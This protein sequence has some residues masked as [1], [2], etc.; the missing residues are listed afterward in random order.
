MKKLLLSLI[1]ILLLIPM[2][3]LAE[4]K[5]E[6]KSITFV[7]KSENTKINTEASTDGE[8]INLDLIFY[9]K[10][11]FATYKV[12]IYNPN[13]IDLFLN[14]I[15][16]NYDKEY[17]GYEFDSNTI[18]ANEEK[19][20]TLRVNYKKEVD[21]SLFRSGKYDASINE[22]L[23]FSSELLNI[24]NT[25]KN[26]GILRVVFITLI[27]ICVFFGF[28][29]IFKNDNK[30]VFNIILIGLLLIIIPKGASAIIKI[31]VPIDSKVIIKMV[32]DNPCVFEGNLTQGA[33]YINGQY[34]YRYMQHYSYTNNSGVDIWENI[35]DDG[36]GVKLTDLNSTDPVNSKLC[37]SINGKPIVSMKS[38][39]Y[40]SKAE[41]IDLSSFD[42][43]N[44][45]NM[46]S[47]FYKMPNIISL[48]VSTFDTSN[49][50]KMNGM[51]SS[52]QNLEE[53]KGL[54]SFDTSL[55]TDAGYLFGGN[56]KLSKLDL[57][58]F[59]LEK[60]GSYYYAMLHECYSL[61]EI[62]TPYKLADSDIYLP[63]IYKDED[64]KK[65][66]TIRYPLTSRKL[67]FFTDA[68]VLTY[69]S[70]FNSKIRKLSGDNGQYYS[71]N[72]Y[73][74]SIERSNERPNDSII[75]NSNNDISYY[76]STN[77]IYAWYNNGIIY[78]Y[79]E[80]DTIYVHPDSQALFRNLTSLEYVDLTEFDFSLATSGE[81]MFQ[82]AGNN[83]STIN[84]EGIEDLYT[85][86]FT[87][88]AHMLDGFNCGY[89]KTPIDYSK[90][91]TSKVTNMTSLFN[92]YGQNNSTFSLDISSWDVSNVTTAENFA[93]NM[94][95]YSHNPTLDMHG[96]KFSK[97]TSSYGI[98]NSAF[99]YS[100]EVNMDL[101]GISFD[102]LE[103]ASYM[104]KYLGGG[105]T[106]IT[107]DF[108]DWNTPKLK[109]VN[110]FFYYLGGEASEINFIGIEDW[111][112]STINDAGGMFY[113]V[114][115]KVPSPTL[116][117]SSWDVSNITNM[118][119]MFKFFGEYSDTATLTLKNWKIN[120]DADLSNF[121]GFV[122]M[123][124]NNVYVNLSGWDVS[125]VL[126]FSSMLHGIGTNSRV[127]AKLDL[128]NW[129]TTGIT[130]LRQLFYSDF[131]DTG[132]V[133]IVMTGWDTSSV[134][135]MSEMFTNSCSNSNTCVITGLN[136]L[137]T[138][139]VTDMSKM[140]YYSG[141]N[142][143]N[144]IVPAS[145]I[146][147]MFYNS[148]GLKG[149]ITITHNP[150]DYSSMLY[151]ASTKSGTSFTVN[152]KAE[153]VDIDNIIA[154]KYTYSNVIK[155]SLIED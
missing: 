139:N 64:D 38:M 116:D 122:G 74:R 16:F 109:N 36:W 1:F 104:F 151:Q 125:E 77:K 48:D 107:I 43:S 140:F 49:V 17:I 46:N 92:G 105:S 126:N 153:V 65:Y 70:T 19:E 69:G 136:S 8:K 147:N 54:T 72:T 4:E 7:E 118:N 95:S 103:N 131:N 47:M 34:T 90:W 25:L 120:K 86:N 35:T 124:A 146:S 26:N 89:N 85:S 63:G 51:F 14:D 97:L 119:S 150:T 27:V 78:Y 121:V 50:T 111:D 58:S 108:S 59:N 73:I 106:K 152:Y 37:T 79:T 66:F 141:I 149:S 96:L 135:N 87:T 53:I 28:Y 39:F 143:N 57:S 132:D 32:K 144:F 60:T 130:S 148:N 20:F 93:E 12:V 115:E 30:S 56:S 22:P 40:Y 133:E 55:V 76:Y 154:T 117:L 23:I 6:I 88:M 45:V 114:Y 113:G 81:A 31:E 10:D 61:K 127:K 91:D 84:Y 110:S 29:V 82:N 62:I 3:V 9:D 24:P 5:V 18:K 94:G 98:F 15:V 145:N 41:S 155:G 134:T 52:N 142:L 99:K 112:M 71:S 80:G 68:T 75:N 42:T 11:D 101:S 2:T 13:D 67:V 83:A 33:Q 100:G 102:S 138:S 129:K 44:V 21:K 123:T 137:D 128:S